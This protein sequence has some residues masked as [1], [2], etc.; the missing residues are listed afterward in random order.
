MGKGLETGKAFLQGVRSKITDPE[1][2]AAFDKVF[3]NETVVTEV[4]N[5]VEGQAEI[6]RQLQTLRDQQTA[7]E[8]LQGKVETRYNEQTAWWN[9]NKD[10]LE[11][12][13]TLKASGGKIPPA[14]ETKTP[15]A[16]LTEE[17]LNQTLTN[18]RA[19]F[20]GYSRDQQKILREHF[21]RFHEI[22]DIEPLLL[23]PDIARLGLVGVY[24][25]VHKDRLVQWKTDQDKKAEDL[26]R[27]DERQK[28][29]AANANMPYP[30]PTGIG[31]GSP[32]DALTATAAKDS[33]T[34]NAVAHYQRL[35]Q[36]RAAGTRT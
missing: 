17:Q 3:G 21:N 27:A 20:L 32:L 14:G 23:D 34:D 28:I 31:S 9:T 25:K 10:A 24:E 8:E 18:E 33:V 35:Q 16:G 26:I 19:A 6:D 4:G 5:G 11:E 29:Q 1:Q 15:P 30:V 36:E 7:L 12:Y 13:K 22:V 2:L